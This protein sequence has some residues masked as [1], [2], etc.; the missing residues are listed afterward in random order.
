[1]L[2]PHTNLIQSFEHRYPRFVLEA[3]I[4]DHATGKNIVWADGEYVFLGG[5]F[6]AS[7]EIT[8]AKITGANAH[9]IKPRFAK[10]A[11]AQ[12]A[13]TKSRAEV[14]TPSWLVNSMNNHLCK[15]WFGRRGVFSTETTTAKG[16]KT[17][18]ANKAPI[19]FSA[20]ENKSWQAYVRARM[21]EITCGEAPFVCSRYDSASGAEIAVERRIGFLD[22]KLRVVAEN[23]KTQSEWTH[24][25][26]EALK[27]SFGFEYQGDNLLIARINVFETFV[28]HFGARFEKLPSS[29]TLK[30]VA[31]IISWNFW[32]MDGFTCAVPTTELGAVAK[33]PL[34]EHSALAKPEK[35]RQMTIFDFIPEPEPAQVEQH[36]EVNVSLCVLYDYNE[37]KPFEFALLKRKACPMNK[38]FY[39]VIGN[40][41]Y[42]ETKGE[43]KNVDI[44]PHFLLESTRCADNVCMIHPGRWIIP[45]KQMRTIHEQIFSSGLQCFEY[46][47]DSRNQFPSI[48]PIDGGVSITCLRKEYKG[49]VT[50]S[51][52]GLDQGVYDDNGI[53]FSNEFESEAYKKT[54]AFREGGKNI[55]DRILGNVGSL[56]GSEFGYHKHSMLNFVKDK[57]DGMSEP[58]KLWA[59]TGFGKGTRFAWHY[60]DKC[61][62]KKVPD[63]LF[64]TRKV[65]IDKKGHSLASGK[66]NI[67]NNIPQIVEKNASASGDVL[68]VIPEQDNDYDLELIKSLFM[69]KTARFLMSIKQK[70][71]YTRGFEII[72]D[73]TSFVPMLSGEMF[74]DEF[75]YKTFDFSPELQAHI[76]ACVSEKSHVK[77]MS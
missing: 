48:P 51:V 45:K 20:D 18:A 28:E 23:T 25:A 61:N 17:W 11:L 6:S 19:K 67:I 44:W 74:S 12:S 76:E 49:P 3:L 55:S 59:N 4:R 68:F 26:L 16:C 37:E 39:A 7:D 10:A 56:G 70:D 8:L 15:V 50:Y 69:T 22:R 2:T 5:G 32:Q 64:E 29:S 24:W 63:I 9:V 31:N 33:T 75:F 53:F 35:P 58:I 27:A 41:P 47:S 30:E 60:I 36:A 34:G 43:T 46:Y 57:T 52:N 65:M 13:R 14:F 62:L 21:L 1:M 54:E 40:P 38:K 71:L 73:Y 66:G 72:P 77:E 42:Q